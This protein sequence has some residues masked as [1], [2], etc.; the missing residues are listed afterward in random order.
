MAHV[1]DGSV[2]RIVARVD[3]VGSPRVVK[4][5]PEE[6]QQ[7]NRKDYGMDW[8]HLVRLGEE[9]RVVERDH[10]AGAKVYYLRP[11]CEGKPSRRQIPAAKKII[12]SYSRTED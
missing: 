12:I 6:S 9:N 1:T 8:T 11:V 7:W 5:L 10:G 3:P 2:T 4:T